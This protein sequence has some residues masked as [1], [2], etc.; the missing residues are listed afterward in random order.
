MK[1][2]LAATTTDQ[3]TVDP[4]ASDS[5][6]SPA[7]ALEL[8]GSAAPQLSVVI[9]VFNEEE[10]LGPLREQL[11][12]A[13]VSLH[14]SF[15]IIF[16][17]D[18]STDGSFRELRN[19]A[20]AEP[21]VR[22]IRFRRNFGQT[23][24]LQAGIEYSRGETIVFIDADLQNDPGDIGRLLTKLEEGYDVVSGWRANRQDSLLTRTIPS[25][26]ANGLISKVT[27]VRLHDYGCTLKAYRRDVI[28]GVKL[29]GEM[30]RFIP[31]FAALAGASVA[32]LPVAHHGRRFGQSKYGLT[33]TFRVLL[34]LLT[35]KF[36]L[37]YSTKP[38]Y[39]FGFAAM[40]L[41]LMASMSG[42]AVIVQR[43][44]P[45]Y[46]WA[47]NNPLLLLAVFL[48]IVGTQ[49]MMMGLLAE[50]MVRTYHESQNKPTYLV[51]QVLERANREAA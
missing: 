25:R 8:D 1:E 2:L 20:D 35:V 11:M 14:R 7:P 33:R 24:A 13:L 32:E 6:R 16:V 36:L 15:E 42:L 50:L 39:F 29:Y 47:H 18:G 51:R 12:V 21:C 40:G 38:A 48:A 45:P 43:L 4:T 5:P 28:G 44:L 27:G 31:A 10:S 49:F 37:D 23:A 26:L 3:K 17:D 46:P 9:P 41:W 19:I 34:D 22:V 30:H